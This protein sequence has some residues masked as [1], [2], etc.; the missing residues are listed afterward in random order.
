MSINHDTQ[1]VGST[2][3]GLDIMQ[4]LAIG[5]IYM[6][7]NLLVRD[8]TSAG[9]VVKKRVALFLEQI[10]DGVMLRAGGKTVQQHQ[11]FVGLPYFSDC[12]AVQTG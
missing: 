2:H 11:Q 8:K 4:K 9:L 6:L 12:V 5:N 3:L 10:R 1:D 7:T